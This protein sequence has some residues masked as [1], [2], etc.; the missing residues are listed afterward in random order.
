ASAGSCS[1][2]GVVRDLV[3]YGSATDFEG[4]V[5]PSVGAATAAIRDSGG[6]ADSDSNAA[7]FTAG[8]PAPRNSTAAATGCAGSAPT[9]SASAAI[10]LDIRSIISLSLERSAISFGSFAAGETPPAVSERVTV[11]SNNATGYW[12]GV[13]RTAF[14]PAD[15]P[16]AISASAPAG[17]TLA[18]PLGA[19][20]KVAI[21][22]AADLLLGV[23]AVPSAAAGDAWPT[24]LSFLSPL[25]ALAP[26]HY[27][28][29]VVYT[30]VGL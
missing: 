20:A 1:A 19:G 9:S 6:C 23:T 10:D 8:T 30:V 26:G 13:R 29:S 22:T 4:A 16:L 3:G 24:S 21:P 11:V 12:L 28:A 17:T 18:A 7:D 5:A 2:V 27:S 25:P 15:L 14:A